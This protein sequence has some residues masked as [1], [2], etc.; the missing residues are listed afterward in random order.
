M[1]DDYQRELIQVA[2][3][4]CRMLLAE[5]IKWQDIEGALVAEVERSQVRWGSQ[6]HLLRAEWLS[7][8]VE[9]VGEVAREIN[10]AGASAQ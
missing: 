5:N 7:I 3:V 8:L 6:D 10:E 1:F 2:N 9:E 4:A